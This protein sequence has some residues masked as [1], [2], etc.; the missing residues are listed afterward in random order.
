MAARRRC[1]TDLFSKTCANLSS[2]SVGLLIDADPSAAI[3]DTELISAAAS[4]GSKPLLQKLHFL[5]ATLNRADQYGWTPL[6]LARHAGHIEA[7]NFLARVDT[8]PS[9]WINTAENVEL[10]ADGLGIKY[11]LPGSRVC[12]STNLPLPAG[13]KKFYF[14]ITSKKMEDMEQIEFPEVAIGLCTLGASAIDFPGWPAADRA[15]RARSWAYHGDDGGF[16]A[17][18]VGGTNDFQSNEDR[19]HGPGDTVG[20][21]VDFEKC[22]MWFTKNGKVWEG[23]EEICKDVRGRLFPVIGI[24][25]NVELETNFGEKEFVWKEGGDKEDGADANG[26]KEETQEQENAEEQQASAGAEKAEDEKAN[27]ALT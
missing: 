26:A 7:E 22:V 20:C 18:K 23:A 6:M 9:R 16:G 5:T 4:N 11:K 3:N 14:E 27:G 24:F 1:Y 25:D 17:T 2:F 8:L 13:H 12:L 15:P 19:R 10:S 21:G